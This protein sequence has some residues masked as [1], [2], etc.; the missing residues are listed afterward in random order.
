MPPPR[1][2]KEFYPKLF[3]ELHPTLNVGIDLNK[4]TCAKRENLYWL[5]PLNP[6]GHHIYLASPGHRSNRGDGCT[7]CSNRAI[8]DCNSLYALRPDLMEIWDFELNDAIGLDPRKIAVNCGKLANWKCKKAKCGHH[9]W[10]AFV[11]HVSGGTGCS[12]CDH[13]YVCICESIFTLCPEVMK[14][15]D[16]EKNDAEGLDPKTISSFS[17]IE[18]Y[19]KCHAT[20]C[21]HHQQKTVVRNRTQGVRCSFCTGMQ[22]CECDSFLTLF[23]HLAKEYDWNKN[24]DIDP[25]KLPR[26][27]NRCVWWKDDK[28]HS[29]QAR[30]C[31]R[32]DGG[33]NCNI[34]CRSSREKRCLEILTELATIFPL[35]CK[36]QATFD[37]CTGRKGRL[38]PFDIR[39]YGYRRRIIIELDG[40]QHF[41]DVY[42]DGKTSKLERTRIN[43]GTK[44]HF[45]IENDIHLLRISFSETK[46]MEKHIKMFLDRV[47]EADENGE[48]SVFM[49][50]GKEYEDE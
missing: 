48:E 18:A 10:R 49:L 14:D 38:L 12:F 11:Y 25:Y 45:C 36:P 19:F 37:G 43:D 13:H 42:F 47:E 35:W 33:N 23:P 8:C 39:V 5:C 24:K 17:E 30:I 1:L 2:L 28:G 6:C 16:Y 40:E 29:W 4:I 20:S 41:Y 46:N 3:A 32:T 22:T 50:C 15:W 34:C 31:A 44:T 9:K 26:A 27:S 21:G 7:F